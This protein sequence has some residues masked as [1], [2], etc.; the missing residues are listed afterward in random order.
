MQWAPDA[1]GGFSR[2]APWLP[3][4]EDFPA[5]NVLNQSRDQV[6]IF[7]LHRRLMALRRE[8]PALA[9][10]TYHPIMTE[11]ELLLFE[12]QHDRERVVV[13]LNLGPDAAS[14]DFGSE[15]CRGRVLLSALGDRDGEP[16]VDR[17]K[18]RG[19]EGLVI[20]ATGETLLMREQ[21]CTPI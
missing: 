15:R 14:V 12:R 3:L 16:V 1:Y 13:A 10:G 20:A 9:V 6:S 7:N 8:T 2:H 4:A 11:G 21:R 17:I 18:L 19:N 5:E